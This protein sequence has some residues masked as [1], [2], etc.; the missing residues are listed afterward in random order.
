[1]I[2]NYTNEETLVVIVDTRPMYRT[3]IKSNFQSIL[4]GCVFL[5]RDSFNEVP[6]DSINGSSVYFMI[7]IGN[8]SDQTIFSSINKARLSQKS[9]KI[10]LYD[11]QYSIHN[12]VDFFK[13][14]INGYL[15]EDFGESELRECVTSIAANRIHLNMQIAVELMI[16]NPR[17]RPKKNY[18]PKNGHRSRYFLA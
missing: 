12:I 4:P 14:K 9:C 6:L 15:P 11:Y 18:F 17:T 5:E 2:Q 8:T 13:E 7:R 1:M 10:I 16:A 3:G